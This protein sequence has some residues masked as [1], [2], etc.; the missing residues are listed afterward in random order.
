M[1]G[2]PPHSFILILRIPAWAARRAPTVETSG[3]SDDRH[4][5]R[6]R[7]DP[8]TLTR[9]PRRAQRRRWRPVGVCYCAMPSLLYRKE[10]PAA[11]RSSRQPDAAIAVQRPRRAFS[12]APYLTDEAYDDGAP[13]DRSALNTT[14]SLE[15]QPFEPQAFFGMMNQLNMSAGAPTQPPPLLTPKKTTQQCVTALHCAD[16]RVCGR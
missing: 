12:G 3:G 2:F 15:A 5:E 4:A 16:R 9:T 1:G 6:G 14:G 8:C 11:D 10:A 7:V 13:T